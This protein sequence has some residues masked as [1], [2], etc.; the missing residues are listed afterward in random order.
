MSDLLI[1]FQQWM[2]NW[3]T[4]QPAPDPEPMPMPSPPKPAPIPP[5][6]ARPT[7]ES[8]V[9]AAINSARSAEGLAALIPDHALGR[10]SS[11]FAA[12][13][14]SASVLDHG[15]FADRIASVYPNTAAGEDIAEGQPDAAS[16]VAAWMGDPPHRAN[17]LGDFNR[18]GVGMAPD[19]SGAIYWCVDFVRIG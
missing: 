14:A 10:V 6:P 12:S 11:R 19:D 17:L 4:P 7:P 18:I 16:V 1:A 8:L 13:M 5:A 9:V 3:F 2:S 15:D